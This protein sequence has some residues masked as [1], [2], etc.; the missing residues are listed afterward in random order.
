M[1]DCPKCGREHLTPTGHE[2]CGGHQKQARG[3]GPCRSRAGAGTDHPGYG[4]C[5]FHGGGG[6][7]GQRHAQRAHAE[8]AVRVY[9]LPVQTTPEQALLDEVHR[10]AGHVAW[11]RERIAD[12]HPDAL[13]WGLTKREQ[14][15]AAEFKGTNSTE[16][17]AVH[18]WLE[19]YLRERRHLV[20]VCA[21]AITAGIAERQVRLAEAQ[22]QLM[23]QALIAILDGLALTEEQREKVPELVDRHLH[24]V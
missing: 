15:G 2:A 5:K 23:A 12:L 18:V 24:A 14:V 19:L 10:T 8:E 9:G 20:D 7:N 16:A 6:R 4:N 22:G 17:A 13:T 21:K 1:A 11:L 3:G